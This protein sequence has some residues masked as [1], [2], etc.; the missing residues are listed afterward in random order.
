MRLRKAWDGSLVTYVT[1]E[2]G[3][4]EIVRFA[5]TNEGQPTPN[6]IWVT[7]A[8]LSEKL[9]LFRQLIQMFF[10]VLIQR[11]DVIITTGAAPGYFALRFGKLIGARTIWIDS[12]AN[13]E[14]LSKSG[15]EVA[16]YADLWLTQWE[17]LAR[18]E[19]PHHMGSVL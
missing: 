12:I 19:G 16:K 14:E 10:I 13:A 5:A 9:P 4:E 1:T 11:P 7:D 6:F 2:P 18:P 15:K 3:L 17:H 8:N